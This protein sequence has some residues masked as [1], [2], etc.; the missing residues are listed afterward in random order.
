MSL[1]KV[2]VAPGYIQD[3][4]QELNG[5]QGGARSPGP[6]TTGEENSK[7]EPKTLTH[8]WSESEFPQD[9]NILN[10]GGTNLDQEDEDAADVVDE[11]DD[12]GLCDELLRG[13]YGYG[14]EKPSMIQ[15]KAI[16]LALT[17]TDVIAQAQSGTGKTATFSIS[18]L[19]KIDPKLRSCQA[20][21]LAPTRELAMQ[22]Q[23]VM[24][25]LGDYMGVVCH[26]LVGGSHVANDINKL[27][28][29]VHVVIGTPGRI[30]HLLSERHLDLYTARQF[31]LDEADQMLSRGFLDQIKDTFK[32]LPRDVQVIL[33]SATLPPEVLD[34]TDKFMRNP[35]RILV[36]REEL[37]LQ[38]IQQFY[39]NVE[40]EEW[41]LDTLCDIYETI[42][43]ETTI[44]FCNKRGKVE[45]LEREMTRRDFTVSAMHSELSQKDRELVLRSFRTGSSRVLIA[46]DLLSRGIDVQQVSLVINFD[47]PLDRE[48]YIHR[49]GRGGRFGRKGTAI[50]FVTS[51][52]YRKL[53]DL[54]KFY[55][56][57]ILE[58]PSNIASL[59]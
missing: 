50:N 40:R 7:A 37:T 11:F 13:I 42:T 38:G 53:E 48:S 17:G 24:S 55:N 32:Y 18:I 56:T 3:K 19:Q 6:Q 23:R 36:K 57:E 14:F 47:L 4:R 30:L 16:P 51:E 58:M 28:E 25:A 1:S 15:Q 10:N 43:V 31:V 52:D 45:W 59:L 34:I 9:D 35:R 26:A 21:V 27:R 20:L 41:K 46:T 44:I 12:M 2:E 49:I 54:Q 33:V 5:G 22:T 39:V 8:H 29:G